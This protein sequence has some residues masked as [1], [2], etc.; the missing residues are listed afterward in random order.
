MTYLHVF[1]QSMISL[2]GNTQAPIVFFHGWGF[3]SHIWLHTAA[4]LFTSEFDAYFVDLPGFGHSQSMPWKTFKERLLAQLP[5]QFAVLG[6]SMGG[7][8][9]TRLALELPERVTHLINLASSP[10]FVRSNGWP[11]I[12][13]SALQQFQILVKHDPI[14]ALN[15]FAQWQLKSTSIEGGEIAQQPEKDSLQ[16]GLEVLSQWDFRQQLQALTQPVLYLF[17]RLDSI[18]PFRTMTAM[19]MLYPQYQYEMITDAAHAL[20][21]S[22]PKALKQKVQAFLKCSHYR[23]DRRDGGEKAPHIPNAYPPEGIFNG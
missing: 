11:G 22:H 1:R 7:L 18:V 15:D 9:A 10:Y 6:W 23:N 2:D 5:P 19:Q 12:K 16:A 21:L 3:D 17:G 13:C 14:A 8:F 4:R 20:F